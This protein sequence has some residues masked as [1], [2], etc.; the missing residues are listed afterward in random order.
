MIKGKANI[1]M[2]GQWGSTGKG[3]LVGYLA[4]TNDINAAVCDFMSNAGHTCVDDEGKSLVTCQI[5]MAFVNTDCMLL[6]NPG[7]AI[8]IDR[9]KKELE[10]FADYKVADRLMIHPHVAIITQEDR[11]HEKKAVERISSTL[12]G[13]G[14]SLSRKVMRVAK[15]AKHEDALAPYIGDT[16]KATHGIL[17]SGGTVLLEGAQGFDLSINHGWSYPFTTSRDVT[18]M[19]ILNN[20]GVPPFYLGD[21]YGALRTYPIRVGNTYDEDGN[22]VGYSGDFYDDQHEVDWEFVKAQSGAV[23]SQEERTTVTNKVRRVFTFSFSQVQR[24]VEICAPT[25]IFVNFVNHLNAE[26]EGKRTMSELS[27]ESISFVDKLQ[28]F[29]NEIHTGFRSVPIPQISHLGTGAKHSD[30][31]E[32]GG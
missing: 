11:D 20:A 23:K 16:T 28:Y 25:K 14:G 10:M 30:M 7:A 6:I 19:S 21:N 22:E 24:F 8:T 4:L 13:C 26:D 3:K 31:V 2:D 29:F 9:L 5:P 1:V 12:K 15:L 27:H 32:I 17:R 18:T